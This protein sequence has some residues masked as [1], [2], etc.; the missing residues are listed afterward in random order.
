MSAEMPDGAA[1]YREAYFRGL[2]PEPDVWID[3]W[4]DEYMR[5]GP[6]LGHPAR[7]QV[8]TAPLGIIG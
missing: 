7:T 6:A 4:A 5:I 3:Q 2:R 1:V 8:L